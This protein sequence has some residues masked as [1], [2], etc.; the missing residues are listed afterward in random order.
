MFKRNEIL[1]KL[2]SIKFNLRKRGQ[3]RLIKVALDDDKIFI[4]LLSNALR[5]SECHNKTNFGYIT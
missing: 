4:S 1:K 5:I 2:S 3:K